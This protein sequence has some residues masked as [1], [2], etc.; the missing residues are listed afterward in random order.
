ML[1]SIPSCG[2]YAVNT[3][4]TPPVTLTRRQANLSVMPLKLMMDCFA[5]GATIKPTPEHNRLPVKV[6]PDKNVRNPSS[7]K[8]SV[9]DKCVSWMHKILMPSCFMNI[10][11]S[12]NFTRESPHNPSTFHEAIRSSCIGLHKLRDFSYLVPSNRKIVLCALPLSA[13]V[14]T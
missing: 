9:S 8:Y 2:A 12:T 1:N 7:S 14:P 11:S 10:R 5:H 3:F 13:V 4:N 6:P